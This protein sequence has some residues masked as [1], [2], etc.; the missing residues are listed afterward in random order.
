MDE[1][2]INDYPVAKAGR[3]GG[4]FGTDR[5]RARG[6]LRA[7]PWPAILIG[8]AGLAF[9]LVIRV[10]WLDSVPTN[11]T[12][13]EADNL[14]TILRIEET[15]KPGFFGLDWKPQPAMSMYLFIT[16]MDIFGHDIYGLRMASAIL[17]T[18]A[19]I[20]FYLLA[21]RVVEVVPALAA[22]FLL[23]TGRWYLHFS[24]SGW[25]NVHTSLF[26]LVAALAL[27]TGI[28]RRQIRWFMVAGVA[29]SLGLYGY[30][31]GRMILAALLVYAPFAIWW[32]RG[33]RAKVVA[34]YAVLVIT[35]L[36]LFTP[37]VPAIADDWDTFN[38][39]TDKIFVLHEERP[40]LGE[41][42]DFGVL[43]VQTQR[44]IEGFFLLEG[45]VFERERYGPAGQTL[46]DPIT[47]LL[48]LAGLL[49]SLRRWRATALWWVMLLIP[50]VG[51]QVLSIRTPDGAR[52]VMVAPFFYLFVAL[53]LDGLFELVRQ[54][55]QQSARL[56]LV[57]GILLIGVIN[58]Q[59]YANWIR[60]PRAEEVREPAV[61]IADYD[62]WAAMIRARA[63]EGKFGARILQFEE[64]QREKQEAQSLRNGIE[65][66]HVAPNPLETLAPDH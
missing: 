31:S 29:S 28:E 53:A 60:S 8:V 51:T 22:T 41:M 52:A 48:I 58:V 6:R 21:R 26:A 47:G 43:K 63:R 40:Y 32:T 10:A 56:A 34:G 1:T 49:L 44:V 9:A 65:E 17:S 27:V 42:S 30:F 54:R 16:S 3:T 14:A 24:R 62:A 66:L 46:F 23:A 12:A 18:L 50:L 35:C 39:R 37:Q 64:A 57:A 15:G 25:E 5:Q 11:I 45:D 61:E 19:L 36:V 59:S 33:F 13:D 7:L 4:L 20:P 55:P 38:R 2:F